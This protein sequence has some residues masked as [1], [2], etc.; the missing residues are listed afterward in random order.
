MLWFFAKKMPKN[1]RFWLRD[2]KQSEIM[3]KMIVTR[4]LFSPKTVKNCRKSS[5]F[6]ENYRKSSKIVENCRKLSKIVE[7]CRKLSKIAE[8]CANNIDTLLASLL[9]ELK[10]LKILVPVTSFVELIGLLQFFDPPLQIVLYWLQNVGLQRNFFTC[11]FVGMTVE[12][13]VTILGELAPIGWLF[14]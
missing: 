5:K 7:N 14:T 12:I 13:S 8:N 1:G 3:Q 6:V 2:S 4:K 10:E 11:A 9:V